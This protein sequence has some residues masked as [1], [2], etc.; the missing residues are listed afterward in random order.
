MYLVMSILQ[1]QELHD[2]NMAGRCV[3]CEMIQVG[4]LSAESGDKHIHEP[5]WTR[6]A[7]HFHYHALY[8][9]MRSMT[10]HELASL[11]SLSG[12]SDNN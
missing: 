9:A 3:R 7:Y 10:L 2:S 4:M 6:D 12:P 8:L 5:Y 1:V 11:Q